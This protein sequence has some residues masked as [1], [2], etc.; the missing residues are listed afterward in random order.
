MSLQIDQSNKIEKT[1]KD[2]A[3]ALANDIVCSIL[4][5][6][7]VKRKLQELF[8]KRG[9]TRIFIYKTF[10]AGIV[11][12]L[13]PHLSKIDRVVIDQEYPGKEKMIRSMIY[14]ILGRFCDKIPEIIFERIG[15]KSKAHEVAHHVSSKEQKPNRVIKFSEIKKLVF[16]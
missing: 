8:R 10:A 9:R 2:T 4:I 1:N 16:P 11:L 7:K 5:P 3:L 12:L 6:G 15:K 14:G 13:K